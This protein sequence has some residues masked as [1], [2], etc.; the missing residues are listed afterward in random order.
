MTPDRRDCLEELAG[1]FDRHVEDFG[2]RLALEV[3]LKRLAVVPRSVADLTRDVDVRQEVHLDLDRA[4]A[5]AGFTAPALDVEREPALLIAA[6]LRL[7]CLGEELADV[8]EDAGVGG[9]V[10]PWRA[11]D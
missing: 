7:S 11:T 2:N 10:G 4:V 9:S 8:I 5:A 6:N 1:L 3:N